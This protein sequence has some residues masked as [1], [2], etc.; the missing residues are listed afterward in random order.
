MAKSPPTHT[1][2]AWTEPVYLHQLV[3]HHEL[4]RQFDCIRQRLGACLVNPFSTENLTNEC[5]VE[6]YTEK[7]KIDEE[8]LRM[9]CLNG[10][11]RAEESDRSMDVDHRDDRFLEGE[12]DKLNTLIDV[13]DCEPHA[14]IGLVAAKCLDCGRHLE[15]AE[16]DNDHCEH[17]AQYALVSD[18]KV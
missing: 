14:R 5:N 8:F 12:D 10:V 11:A 4:D 3:Q 6:A 17:C 9:A 2:R 18:D 15:N 13:V 7:V 1:T 16:V